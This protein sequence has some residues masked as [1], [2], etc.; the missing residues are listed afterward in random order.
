MSDELFLVRLSAP[1]QNPSILPPTT[2]ALQVV[3]A[4]SYHP[5]PDPSDECDGVPTRLREEHNACNKS[6]RAFERRY[7]GTSRLSCHWTAA[8][9]IKLRLPVPD[10]LVDFT[11]IYPVVNKSFKRAPLITVHNSSCSWL[12]ICASGPQTVFPADS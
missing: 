7:F 6:Q 12:S 9:Q 1:G 8:S 5:R 2:A 11:E 3:S 10:Y 4:L